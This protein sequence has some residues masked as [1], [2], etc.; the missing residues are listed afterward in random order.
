[1]NNIYMYAHGGSGNHGC[2]AIVRST[3]GLLENI[4]ANK[5]ILLSSRSKEDK[6]Y[7]VS[8]LCEVIDEKS[9]YS[10]YSVDFLSAYWRLKVKKDYIY[11]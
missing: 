4:P 5:I 1:M 10:K 3:V 11:G 9:S 8:E 7:G 2:E 6:K